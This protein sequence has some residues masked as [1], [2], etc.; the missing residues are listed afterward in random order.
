MTPRLTQAVDV[1][2]EAKLDRRQLAELAEALAV[3]GP[4]ELSRL[5]AAF[6]KSPNA[7]SYILSKT[8]RTQSRQHSKSSRSE[9]VKTLSPSVFTQPRT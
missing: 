8:R 2:V 9:T 1:L 4:M 5:M 3:T 6:E 7:T